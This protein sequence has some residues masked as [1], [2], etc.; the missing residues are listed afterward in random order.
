MI[1]HLQGEVL[2]S[3]GNEVVV[4]TNSGIGY[5]IFFGNV[6]VEGSR[7]SVFISH[8]IKEGSEELYG[9][10][11]LRDKKTFEMLIKVKGVGP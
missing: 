3:D 1:G 8:V 9:F 4:L 5:Q 11:T 6:L 2:F 7:A 10:K